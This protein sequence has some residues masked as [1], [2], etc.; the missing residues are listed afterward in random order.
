MTPLPAAAPQP[1]KLLDLLLSADGKAVA[2]DTLLAALWP[3][4]RTATLMHLRVAVH[5]ARRALKGS[6][7]VIWHRRGDG[8][9]LTREVA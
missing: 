6:G 5:A 4:S 1:T 3:E 2:Y 7:W 9:L 8:Y